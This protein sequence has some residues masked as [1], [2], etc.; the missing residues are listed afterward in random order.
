[1][2][3]EHD[4]ATLAFAHRMFELARSVTPPPSQ[5]FSNRVSPVNLTTTRATPC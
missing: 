1:M 5:G 3:E 2:A 4:D